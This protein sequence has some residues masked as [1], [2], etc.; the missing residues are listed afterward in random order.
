MM[1]H[2]IKTLLLLA[3][4][5]TCV[6][7]GT[8]ISLKTN[9]DFSRIERGMTKEEVKKILGTPTNV[10]F[11]EARDQ[12]EYEKLHAITGVE[13]IVLVDFENDRVVAVDT[14]NP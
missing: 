12:W 9:K 14:F 11:I 8:T 5:A 6:A 3:G 13:T 4:I 7:C 2:F 10:R 1:K